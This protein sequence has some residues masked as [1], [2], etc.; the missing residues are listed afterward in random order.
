MQ[1]PCDAIAVLVH[2]ETFLFGAGQ[3]QGDRHSDLG[4]ELPSQVERICRRLPRGIDPAEDDSTMISLR[5]HDRQAHRLGTPHRHFL[6]LVG[7]ADQSHVGPGDLT[8]LLCR[9]THDILG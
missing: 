7:T 3:R 4:C 2:R 8:G 1:I 5:S 9:G 6:R